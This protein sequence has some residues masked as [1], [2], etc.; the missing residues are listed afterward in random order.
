MRKKST[1][2]QDSALKAWPWLEADIQVA[3]STCR[4]EAREAHRS[5]SLKA[6]IILCKLNCPIDYVLQH[7][8]NAFR[9]RLS[10]NC[11]SAS[12]RLLNGPQSSQGFTTCYFQTYSLVMAPGWISQLIAIGFSFLFI[13]SSLGMLSFLSTSV[14][15]SC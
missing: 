7:P 12:A 3:P 10:R 9:A 13:C 11:I 5:R 2:R 8:S 4:S 1:D 6:T 14:C 15:S